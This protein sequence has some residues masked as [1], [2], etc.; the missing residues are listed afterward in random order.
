LDQVQQQERCFEDR[1][2]VKERWLAAD[3]GSEIVEGEKK[4]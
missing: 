4:I 1:D 3:I 2:K